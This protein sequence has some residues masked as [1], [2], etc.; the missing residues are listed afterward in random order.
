[1]GQDVGGRGGPPGREGTEMTYA[2][3]GAED[4]G[5]S[6]GVCHSGDLGY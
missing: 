3:Q 1:M 4:I 6:D 2:T 5:E